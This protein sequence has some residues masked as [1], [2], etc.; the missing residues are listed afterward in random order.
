MNAFSNGIVGRR[1]RYRRN[2]HHL[3]CNRFIYAYIIKVLMIIC[4]LLI[5]RC[6]FV[7]TIETTS[8]LNIDGGHTKSGASQ[9][10]SMIFPS[11]TSKQQQQTPSVSPSPKQQQQQPKPSSVIYIPSLDGIIDDLRFLF[12][13]IHFLTRFILYSNINRMHV[14][15]E[16]KKKHIKP[17]LGV[18]CISKCVCVCACAVLTLNYVDLP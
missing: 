13:F 2:D 7:K 12:K 16:L 9:I 1:H 8:I 11:S 14:I 18:I 15:E 4:V 17:F 3:N 6:G 10:R 5:N